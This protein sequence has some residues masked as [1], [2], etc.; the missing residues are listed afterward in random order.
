ML[1]RAQI[2]AADATEVLHGALTEYRA[3]AA[4]R[5][6]PPVGQCASAVPG[7]GEERSVVPCDTPWHSRGEGVTAVYLP[8]SEVML[9][10]DVRCHER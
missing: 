1:H 9:A 4:E 2:H 10:A 8:S 7:R 3:S 6:D 5:G